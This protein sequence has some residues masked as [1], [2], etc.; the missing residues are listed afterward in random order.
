MYFSGMD[1]EELKDISF[2]QKI[3]ALLTKLSPLI[4]KVCHV[5]KFGLLLGLCYFVFIE[6][7][8]MFKKTGVYT[9]MTDTEWYNVTSMP[10]ECQNKT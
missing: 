3:L 9:N 8:T 4:L 2:L 1:L 7:G 5:L 10:V 6:H